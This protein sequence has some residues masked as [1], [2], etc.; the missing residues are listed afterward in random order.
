[1]ESVAIRNFVFV[2]EFDYSGVDHFDNEAKVCKTE[3]KNPKKMSK[4]LK[5]NLFIKTQHITNTSL[6]TW[7]YTSVAR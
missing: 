5:L 7:L 4:F 2:D 1:M 6:E 3:S